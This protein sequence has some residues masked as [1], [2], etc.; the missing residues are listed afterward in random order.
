[1]RLVSISVE[2]Y[3]SI[4]KAPKIR[5]GRSTVLV[6]PNNEGKSN[7]LRAL[8]AGMNILTAQRRLAGLSSVRQG[9]TYHRW[10]GYDWEKDFP[11]HLQNKKPNG[12]S[13]ITLEFE[14]NAEDLNEFQE[15]IKS[16][17][18]G[19]L[20]IRIALGPKEYKITVHKQGPGSKVLTSKS[21]KIAAFLANRLDLEYIP[22]V[23]TAKSAEEI[24]EGMVAREL[25]KLE[26]NREYQ[27]ALAKI[28]ELQQPLLDTLSET[29]QQTLIKFLPAVHEVRV[30]IP[31]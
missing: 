30:Q 17:L 28:A 26:G 11:I 10:H 1:M 29:I 23:R 16:T 15:E 3:R 22:A 18:N 21:D 9:T 27:A 8:V 13:V 4:T 31:Q 6:G 7:I 24:V 5:L 12:Q 14:F 2:N 19:T 20:P 25:M